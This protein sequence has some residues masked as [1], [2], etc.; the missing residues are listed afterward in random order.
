MIKEGFAKE[1]DSQ[2]EKLSNA[3]DTLQLK[4]IHPDD[5]APEDFKPLID[6]LTNALQCFNKSCKTIKASV[7]ARQHFM[8]HVLTV[9][10]Q[11]GCLVCLNPAG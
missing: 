1:L 6:N 10:T 5:V 7:V 3:L 2:E 8:Q 11:F 4:L 9:S